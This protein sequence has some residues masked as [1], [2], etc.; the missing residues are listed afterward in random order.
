MQFLNSNIRNVLVMVLSAGLFAC[1]GGGG[2]AGPQ[3]KKGV[4][5]DSPVA[6]VQYQTATKSGTTNAAGEF[7]YVDGESVIFSIGGIQFP[8]VPAKGVVTPLD[9]AGTTDTNNQTAV[10][11]LRLLQTLDSNG[12]PDDGISISAGVISAAAGVSVDFTQSDVDFAA[13][14]ASFL[15]AVP[16][17]P[18]LVPSADAQAHFESTLF[19]QMSGN[20]SGTFSGDDSGTWQITIDKDGKISGVSKSDSDPDTGL[21]SGKVLADGSTTVGVVDGG[22]S[23]TFTG[24]I[25]LTGE[26]SGTWSDSPESGTF[27]GK[28]DGPLLVFNAASVAGSYNIVDD[29]LPGLTHV[30]TFNADGTGVADWGDDPIDEGFTWSVDEQGRL[31]VHLSSLSGLP[32]EMTLISGT[33]EKGRISARFDDDSNGVYEGAAL[34]S[35]EKVS[36]GGSGEGSS[37]ALL[38]FN[39]ASVPGSYNIVDDA[40][41]GVTHVYTF[42]A[43]GTGVAD[44]GDDPVDEGFSW[45]VDAQGR[46]IVHLSSLSGLPDEIT[47]ISGTPENGRVRA[48]FDDDSNGTYEGVALASIVKVSGSGTG[49]AV[50]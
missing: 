2:G 1:G 44:W 41:P 40:L 46:L 37:P 34:A 35:F 14:V 26:I 8:P 11:I 12:N 30:Y 19:D 16:G 49:G 7:D 13:S 38:A 47:L 39:D 24:T 21:L 4:L 10:N 42:N 45:S 25:K 5:L 33:L 17:T 9:M 23:G 43:D 50:L 32:D 28:K 22:G 29:A 36:G 31:I 20:Y 48:R 15:S 3:T 6:G 18:A 27:T